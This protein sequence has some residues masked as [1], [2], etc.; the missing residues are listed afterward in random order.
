M[1]V[2]RSQNFVDH[3]KTVQT[4]DTITDVPLHRSYMVHIAHRYAQIA[5][6]DMHWTLVYIHVY[7]LTYPTHCTMHIFS[8]AENALFN[9]ISLH[10]CTS[11]KC[12]WDK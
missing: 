1:E 12:A 7:I 5:Y 4:P 11:Y 8:V 6:L 2:V 10:L 3:C 9:L